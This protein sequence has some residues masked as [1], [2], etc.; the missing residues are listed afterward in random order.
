MI[1]NPLYVKRIIRKKTY[2]EIIAIFEEIETVL[3]R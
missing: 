3:E 2:E 1:K